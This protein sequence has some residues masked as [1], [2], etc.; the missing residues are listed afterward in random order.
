MLREGLPREETWLKE[1]TKQR[2]ER[3]DFLMEGNNESK[4]SE[5]GRTSVC[6]GIWK[7]RRW[8]MWHWL[9]NRKEISSEN[10]SMGSGRPWEGFWVLNCDMKISRKELGAMTSDIYTRCCWVETLFWAGRHVG[11]SVRRWPQLARHKTI[12]AW[13]REVSSMKGLRCGCMDLIWEGKSQIN[14]DSGAWGLRKMVYG[15]TIC[16]NGRDGVTDLHDC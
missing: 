14:F 16:W 11:R 6:L 7:S 1:S 2:I 10:N 5:A 12:V 3:R 9:N 4:G 13:I 8:W 15:Y